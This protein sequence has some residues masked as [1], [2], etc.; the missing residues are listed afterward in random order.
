MHANKYLLTDVLKG[1]LGFKGFLISDWQAI[2]QISN[3]YYLAVITSINAGLDM[4][5]VPYD[6]GSFI[7]TLKKAVENRDVPMERIDDAVR[8]I[9]TVKFMMGLF[10]HPF[11]DPSL[12]PLIGS[13]ELTQKRERNTPDLQG[14]AIDLRRRAGRHRYRPAMRRLDDRL[15]G[16]DWSYRAWDDDPGRDS[17]SRILEHEGRL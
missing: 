13:D 8:R 10:E 9:L 2:D 7:N 6:Y 16:K 11:S 5:M 3:D 17:A 14:N 4:N 12:L 15:A 1:E